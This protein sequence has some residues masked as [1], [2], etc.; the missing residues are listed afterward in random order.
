M[1]VIDIS[2]PIRPGMV[3][4]PGDPVPERHLHYAMSAGA[5]CNLS[6]LTLGVHTGTHVD[7]PFHTIPDGGTVDAMRPEHLVGPAQVVEPPGEGH[8]DA[9][10]LEASGIR[11]ETSRVL[12]RTRNSRESSLRAGT[13]DEGFRAIAPDGA[14]W[15]VRR[16]V[17]VVGI[18][19][20]SVQP[21]DPSGAGTHDTLLGAG[22]VA[23]EGCDLTDVEPGD[24][25]LVCAP[26][27]LDGA[28]GAPARVFL[29]Q[30]VT[31]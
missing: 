28:D 12:F 6:L 25:L 7:A 10:A 31:A 4:W 1:K 5:G 26:L 30:D 19:Y 21:K 20:L 8:I 2:M 22:V 29:L 14:A 3:V 24:Y 13:F 18:D 16:G 27:L 15:L 17:R 11:P 9:A 23:I